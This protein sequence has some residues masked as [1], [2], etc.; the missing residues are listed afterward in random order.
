MHETDDDGIT[1]TE[2]EVEVRKSLDTDQSRHL[3]VEFTLRSG[4]DEPI[5]IR[6]TDH[7]PESVT[8]EDVDLDR[9]PGT[10]VWS[11]SE[12]KPVFRRWL[13]P[14]EEFTTRYRVSGGHD[15]IASRPLLGPDL[16]VSTLRLEEGFSMN[17]TQSLL[18]SVVA[19]A[20]LSYVSSMLL[21]FLVG[22]SLVL[23][24]SVIAVFLAL[25]L[26][27]VWKA[28]TKAG[29]PGW[30]AIVPLYN[31]YVMLRI[32]GNPGWWLLGLLVPFLNI[33][34]YAVIVIDVAKAFGRGVGFGF[35]LGFVPFVFWPLLG[36]G[37]DS[38]REGSHREDRDRVIK[39]VEWKG[40]LDHPEFATATANALRSGSMTSLS[41]PKLQF[42]IEAVDAYREV[43]AAD[44]D[45]DDA[46]RT[47]ISA[48]ETETGTDWKRMESA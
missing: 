6:L 30:K 46:R 38:Y 11:M 12:G 40:N 47:L 5:E 27:G 1:V 19:I 24:M 4:H 15:G 13:G 2:D 33:V 18:L 21:V 23:G 41:V 14:E 42:A 35:G 3:V 7:L 22:Y 44:I 34:V 10:G 28:F 43:G 26:A 17:R 16:A 20:V 32:G 29:Q 31:I 39:A 36:F 37:D 8:P 25:T 45:F 48:W 9:R